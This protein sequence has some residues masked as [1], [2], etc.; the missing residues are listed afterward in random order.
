MDEHRLRYLFGVLSY[1]QD[2]NIR[3]SELVA[4]VL[5]HKQ[6]NQP[7]DLLLQDLVHKCQ[8]I[9]SAFYDHP[10][11]AAPTSEW[12]H[13]QITT[14]YTTAVRNLA[15]VDQGWHF[16]VRH[17]TPDQVR[18]FR[19]EDM[20]ASMHRSE[21]ELWNLVFSLLGGQGS[22]T[23]QSGHQ[24]V[25]DAEEAQYW[26]DDEDVE[27][28]LSSASRTDGRGGKGQRD[29]AGLIQIVSS[30]YSSAKAE[31]RFRFNPG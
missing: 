24:E 12:A 4:T 16:R 6:F 9:L 18:D 11:T 23:D 2:S 30:R 21:P 8:D 7:N 5:V 22:L 3:L 10:T 27:Q 31:R 20:A 14:R 17:A 25:E 26:I 28:M 13:D 15:D 29:C 1:L 19:L